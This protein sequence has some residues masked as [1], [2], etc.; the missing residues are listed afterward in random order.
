MAARSMG[1]NSGPVFRRLW[2]R[3]HQSLQHRFPIDVLSRSRDI[4]DQVTISPKFWCFGRQI[5]GEG[6]TQL[7]DWIL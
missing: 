2:T 1:Q 5:W 6:A 4:R 3:L 7:S